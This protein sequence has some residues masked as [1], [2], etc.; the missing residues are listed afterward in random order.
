M[1]SATPI[2]Q[3]IE[4]GDPRAADQ[5]LPLVDDELRKIAAAKLAWIP[6]RGINLKIYPAG[7]GGRNL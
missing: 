2:L 3:A 6:M 4:Q 5:W 7:W 1:T